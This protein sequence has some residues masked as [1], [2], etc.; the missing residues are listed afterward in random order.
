M[1]RLPVTR[2][3]TANFALMLQPAGAAD[4]SGNST[5]RISRSVAPAGRAQQHAVLLAMPG[6]LRR[7]EAPA[8]ESCFIA[9]GRDFVVLEMALGGRLGIERKTST[10]HGLIQARGF[11]VDDT[12]PGVAL[13]H[14]FVRPQILAMHVTRADQLCQLVA[15]PLRRRSRDRA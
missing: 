6:F 14:D 8:P 12:K 5:A 13:R 2:A 9:L 7:H 15:A 11:A 3:R 10:Y 1:P 4:S